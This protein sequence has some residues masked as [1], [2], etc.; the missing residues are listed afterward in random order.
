MVIAA[1]RTIEMSTHRLDRTLYVG[2]FNDSGRRIFNSYER[3]IRPGNRAHGTSDVI[4]FIRPR[5]PNVLK[6]MK[7]LFQNGLSKK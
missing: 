4:V 6:N 3:C 7:I 5:E 2:H 1:Q